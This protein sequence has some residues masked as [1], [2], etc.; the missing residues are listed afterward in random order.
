MNSKTATTMRIVKNSAMKNTIANQSSCVLPRT[1][2]KMSL[3]LSYAKK[4]FLLFLMTGMSFIGFSQT[5]ILFTV[6]NFVQTAPNVFR[7]D[8]MMTNTGTTAISV[9]GY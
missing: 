1:T 5:A 2:K 3:H 8:V 9:R 4:A 6:T 7:Y